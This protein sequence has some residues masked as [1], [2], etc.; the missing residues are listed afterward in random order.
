[1]TSGR[2]QARYPDGI[3]GLSPAPHTFATKADA[4]RWL[5]TV[6][7]DQLRGAWI[8]PQHGKVTFASYADD[9]LELIDTL[10]IAG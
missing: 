4:A 7:A 1:M 10:D 2:W 5:A 8:D 3:G 9:M 6:E